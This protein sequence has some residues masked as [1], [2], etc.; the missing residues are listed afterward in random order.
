MSWLIAFKLKL[1]IKENAVSSKYQQSDS[2]L[3]FVPLFSGIFTALF[4]CV[5]SAPLF[6]CVLFC[7]GVLSSTS[8]KLACFALSCFGRFALSVVDS[9]RDRGRLTGTCNC[10]TNRQMK[11]REGMKEWTVEW[12]ETK[13]S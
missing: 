2:L 3:L 4:F 13:L 8:L 7:I 11:C 10:Q 6:P 12:T 5:F 9:V 1:K